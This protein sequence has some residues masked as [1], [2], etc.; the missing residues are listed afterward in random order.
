MFLRIFGVELSSAFERSQLLRLQ[1]TS[2]G[3]RATWSPGGNAVGN[4]RGAE[5]KSASSAASP[6]NRVRLHQIWEKKRERERE[7]EICYDFVFFFF[8]LF[9]LFD[10]Q[11]AIPKITGT[12]EAKLAWCYPKGYGSTMG[13]PG[14][15]GCHFRC[16]KKNHTEPGRIQSP[17]QVNEPSPKLWEVPKWGEKKNGSQRCDMVEKD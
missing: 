4:P 1:G 10:L 13:G 9:V 7:R 6:K 12:S 11:L 15:P 8:F 17:K 5:S 16:E 14:M 3:H 2:F